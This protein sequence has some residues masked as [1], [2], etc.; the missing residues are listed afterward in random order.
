MV[1]PTTNVLV[2]VNRTNSVLRRYKKTTAE[3]YGGE[4]MGPRRGVVFL[5]YL[6]CHFIFLLKAKVL[7]AYKCFS[8][9]RE[10]NFVLPEA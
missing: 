3:E 5:C 10:T 8:S 1:I 7:F 4:P 9:T 2:F 6:L